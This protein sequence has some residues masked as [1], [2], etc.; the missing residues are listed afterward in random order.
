LL[1]NK[2]TQQQL[3]HFQFMVATNG[4]LFCIKQEQ[5]G[6]KSSEVHVL[7]AASGYKTFILHTK[8]PIEETNHIFKFLLAPNRDLYAIKKMGTGTKTT[9]VHILSAASNYQ[10]FILQTGTGIEEQGEGNWE[11]VLDNNLNLIGIKKNQTGTNKTEIHTLS[12][13]SGYKQFTLH[14]GTVLEENYF[15]FEFS[16]D[17]SGDIF[18]IKKHDTG[19]GKSELHIMKPPYQNWTL[20]TGTAL[21]MVPPNTNHFAFAVGPNRDLYCIKKS[22]TGTKTTEVHIL[23]A[24]KGYKSFKLH[25]G[26]GLH[27][28]G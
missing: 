3:P 22:L 5:T 11:Y 8:T 27:E 21:E 13:A 25:T 26:S 9:E 2:T 17:G 15:N 20:Q 28:T 19:T 18:A 24:S 10:K 16:S 7:S 6:S 23:D 4:D 14:T 1:K 12:K